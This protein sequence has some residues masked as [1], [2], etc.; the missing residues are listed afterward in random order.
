MRKIDIVNRLLITALLSLT[1]AVEYDDQ[2][3][4][5]NPDGEV[6]G[7]YNTRCGCTDNILYRLK[8]VIPENGDDF[9][10]VA[11]ITTLNPDEGEEFAS[12]S[13]AIKGEAHTEYGS[14]NVTQ[15]VHMEFFNVSGN[16]TRDV[17]ERGEVYISLLK[18]L[19]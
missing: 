19:I 18:D 6:I 10:A 12:L 3:Q 16:I 15:K 14:E 4:Y 13:L 8:T 2:H 9:H 17:E 1:E 11:E 5:L 7:Y